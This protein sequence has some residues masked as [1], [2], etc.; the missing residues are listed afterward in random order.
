M[1]HLKTMAPFGLNVD[2]EVYIL[3]DLP[4]SARALF[5]NYQEIIN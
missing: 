2:E 1:R 3:S 5:C 4:N